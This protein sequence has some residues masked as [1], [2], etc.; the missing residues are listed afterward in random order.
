MLWLHSTWVQF[1]SREDPLEEARTTHSVFLPEE[2]HGQE[3]GG[4][5]SIGCKELDMTKCKHTLISYDMIGMVTNVLGIL[6]SLSIKQDNIFNE[7]KCL[8]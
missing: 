2:S 6:M 8:L 4:L 5:Q 3:S 1:L 7:S